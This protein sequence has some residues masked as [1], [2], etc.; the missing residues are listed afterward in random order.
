MQ[1][2]SECQCDE[3]GWSKP[4]GQIW[5]QNWLPWQRISSDREMNEHLLK[6]F[7]K[8]GEDRS[9]IDYEITFL[10][11]GPQ[12]NKGKQKHKQNI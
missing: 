9:T 3:C 1:S 6:P 7:H 8:F 4:N 11:V 2:V 12:K 5:P 10:E